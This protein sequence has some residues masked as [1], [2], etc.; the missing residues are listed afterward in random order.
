[1]HGQAGAPFQHLLPSA[2]AQ[3]AHLLIHRYLL[4]SQA[5]FNGAR[6]PKAQLQ[7]AQVS[8]L[9]EALLVLACYYRAIYHFAR[10]FAMIIHFVVC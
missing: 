9:R 4:A 10:L 8:H 5:D 3:T 6:F 1:M 2:P 7:Q